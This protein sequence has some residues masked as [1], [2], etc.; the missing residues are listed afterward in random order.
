MQ[1]HSGAIVKTIGGAVMAVFSRPSDAV[2]AALHILGEIAGE[3]CISEAL[4]SAPEVGLLLAG[5]K[6]VAFDAPLRVEGNA[7][8]YRVIGA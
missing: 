6:I 5:H 8:G 3:I 1:E 2:S 4:Y 7:C